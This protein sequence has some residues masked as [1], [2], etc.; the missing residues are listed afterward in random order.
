M[1]KAGHSDFRYYGTIAVTFVRRFYLAQQWLAMVQNTEN[2]NYYQGLVFLS[3]WFQ[4]LEPVREDRVKIDV[5]IIATA[6]LEK[7]KTSQPDHPIFGLTPIL[8]DHDQDLASN[9]L[10]DKKLNFAILDCLNEVMFRDQ[11]FRGNTANYYNP[12]NS[13]IDQVL[14]NK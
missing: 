12:A 7:L 11:G 6:T 5:K 4:P 14:K 1:F 3:Q 9:R 8:L 10:D 13:F 2:N